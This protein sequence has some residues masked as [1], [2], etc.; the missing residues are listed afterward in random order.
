MTIPEFDMYF[1]S[2]KLQI[3]DVFS[4]LKTKG[5]TLSN[6]FATEVVKINT[7]KCY[8]F[9]RKLKRMHMHTHFPLKMVLTCFLIMAICGATD[10]QSS[11]KP[12][13][14]L[15]PIMIPLVIASFCFT[16]EMPTGTLL[17]PARDLGPRLAAWILGWTP[18]S[19]F[20]NVDRE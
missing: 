8:H 19:V 6:G 7:I 18:E 20:L 4:P 2:N 10:K 15:V 17:N 9:A 16:H 13:G 5:C 1:S 3:A 14:F 12:P 11:I